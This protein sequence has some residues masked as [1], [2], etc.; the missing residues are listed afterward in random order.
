MARLLSH[1]AVFWRKFAQLGSQHGP[2]WWVRHSPAFFGLAAAAV[3]PTARKTVLSNLR[4]IRGEASPL[5]DVLDVGRTFTA[6]A[7]CLAEVLSS[8]SK[9]GRVPEGKLEGKS[10]FAAAVAK[11]RGVV[12]VT[13]HS[14]G[15]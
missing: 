8:G 12:L 9:N 1:D 5:R 6:Y 11:G 4:A 13:I 14:G 15:W 3:L 7:G 2:E 10:N